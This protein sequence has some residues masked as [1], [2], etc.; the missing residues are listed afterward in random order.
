MCISY[1]LNLNCYDLPHLETQAPTSPLSDGRNLLVTDGSPATPCTTTAAYPPTTPYHRHLSIFTLLPILEHIMDTAK[2]IL[3][4][5]VGGWAQVLTAQPFDTVKVRLQAN[6][7]AYTGVLDCVRKTAAEGLTTFYAGTTSPLIGIGACV[8]LQFAALNAGKQLVASARG[9]T[10]DELS[11][12]EVAIAGSFAGIANVI[13]SSPVEHLRIRMQVQGISADGPKYNGTVDAVRS[14]YRGH[15]MAGIYRGTVATLWRDSFGFAAYFGAY[16]ASKRALTPEGQEKPGMLTVLASGALAGFAMWIPV[17]PFDVIKSK[18]QT[19]NLAKPQY[20]TL[21]GTARS[22]VATEG[23]SGLFSG[24][25]PCM[26]RAAPVNAVTF[27]AYEAT[28]SLL[29]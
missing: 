5:T 20:R 7:K 8:A 27:L 10:A 29:S 14:I 1:C 19:D 28:K 2:E 16:E 13:A 11:V 12:G 18:W 4:G 25:G 15:G 26:A 6:P 21:V 23:V 22:I 3:A 17:F 24:F 9:K